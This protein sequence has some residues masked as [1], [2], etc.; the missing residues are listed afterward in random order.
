MYIYMY[1][2]IC[3]YIYT[4]THTSNSVFITFYTVFIPRNSHS[5]LWKI[6]AI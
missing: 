2:Y 4:H 1:M 5:Y 6:S 3:V